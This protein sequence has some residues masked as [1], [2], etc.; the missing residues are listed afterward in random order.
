MPSRVESVVT[1]RTRCDPPSWC[2]R[3]DERLEPEANTRTKGLSL[4]VTTHQLTGKQTVHGVAFHR[5]ARDRGLMLNHC[6]W[7]G[8]AIYRDG[9]WPVDE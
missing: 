6:P 3:L 4:V 7:C 1:K 5:S 2:A 9:G 8:E